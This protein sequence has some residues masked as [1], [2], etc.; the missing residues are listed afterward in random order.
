M[1]DFLSILGTVLWATFLSKSG[2]L[3]ISDK[4]VLEQSFH[5]LYSPMTRGNKV[6]N[7]RH[8]S[9][10]QMIF[11]ASTLSFCCPCYEG[12]KKKKKRWSENEDRQARREPDWYIVTLSAPKGTIRSASSPQSTGS[13]VNRLFPYSQC[14]IIGVV[15]AGHQQHFFVVFVLGFFCSKSGSQ[16]FNSDRHHWKTTVHSAVYLHSVNTVA[17]Q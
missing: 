14:G 13:P 10:N 15:V 1:L 5:I 4:L 3:K 11:A 17:F 6:L 2:L 9:A 12:G 7:W 16:Q 8:L